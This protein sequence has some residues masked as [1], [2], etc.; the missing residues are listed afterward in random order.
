MSWAITADAC[1]ALPVKLGGGVL[2]E[3]DVRGPAASGASRVFAG[4]GPLSVR[5][6][7]SVAAQA[8]NGRAFVAV[9]LPGLKS[10]PVDVQR[11]GAVR[12]HV[13]GHRPGERLARHHDR[14]V[15]RFQCSAPAPPAVSVLGQLDF[16]G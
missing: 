10:A 2:I 14:L 3:H 16:I 1:A 4:P 15:G 6:A 12:E 7:V 13:R 11:P 8:D 5:V 9:V